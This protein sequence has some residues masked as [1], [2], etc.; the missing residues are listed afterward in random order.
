M[1]VAKKATSKRPAKKAAAKKAPARK[2]PAKRTSRDPG[3]PYLV[4]VDHRLRFLTD[5][6]VSVD[7]AIASLRGM[8][9]I[10]TTQLPKAIRAMTGARVTIAELQVSGLEDGSFLEDLKIRLLFKSKKDYERCLDKIADAAKTTWEGGTPVL[11]TAIG[12]LVAA[13]VLNGLGMLPAKGNKDALNDV[14]GDNNVVINIG[15]EAYGQD[16]EKFQ[17]LVKD[18]VARTSQKRASQASLDATAPAREQGVAVEFEGDKKPIPMI[19][20]GTAERLPKTVTPSDKSEDQD[21]TKIKLKLRASDTDSDVRG[22][23]GTIPGLVDKRTRVT[24]ASGSNSGKAM[25]RPEVDADVTVTYASKL[26]DRALL[27]IVNK[28]Y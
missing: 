12:V 24:F 25:F 27:I 20:S 15:A 8:E 23:A 22:W 2:S 5:E 1:A 18:A 9:R 17:Q 11:K 13:L 19:S 21:Y 7:A 6:P 3:D 10:V 26:H 14:E 4:V 28:I 16:P